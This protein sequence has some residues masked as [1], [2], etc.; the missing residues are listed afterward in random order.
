MSSQLLLLDRI[1]FSTIKVES[2][3]D[4]EFERSSDFP[5][6]EFDFDKIDFF[7]RSLLSYPME[8]MEDPRHFSLRYGV[9]IDESD[10]NETKTP[11]SIE[12]EVVGFFRYTGGEDFK[13]VERFRAVRFS[14]Y[15]I[16]Y[17]AIREMVCNLTARGRY[18]VWQLPARHFQG[19]AR[20]K[21][22]E[23][24]KQRLDFIVSKSVELVAEKVV[25]RPRKKVEIESKASGKKN[26]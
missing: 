9:K 10:K 3:K 15:Q 4:G 14:G 23:D 18:G 16:L 25:R 13:G 6:L 8:E 21:A 17:G 11:Y 24:E 12:V 26:E 5:Q 2:A 7:T 20:I 1:E 19:V 22:E